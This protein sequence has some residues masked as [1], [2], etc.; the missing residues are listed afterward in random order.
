VKTE[1]EF[2]SKSGWTVF[3]LKTMQ[4]H[5]LSERLLNKKKFGAHEPRTYFS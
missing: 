4:Q 2:I 5:F 1:Q 3:F